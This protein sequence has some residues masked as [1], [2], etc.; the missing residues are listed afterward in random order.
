MRSIIASTDCVTLMSAPKVT[1]TNP[2][3]QEGYA[4]NIISRTTE[5]QETMDNIHII[6]LGHRKQ[7]GKDTVG[8]I[9]QN[10]LENRGVLTNK[11]L[12]A[13][14]LKEHCAERYGLDA[15][16]MHEDE[17]KRWK[18]SWLG[19]R[20]VRDVLLEEGA[21]GRQIWGPVWANSAYKDVLFRAHRPYNVGIITDFR[22]QNEYDCFDE[23]MEVNGYTGKRPILHKVLVHRPDGPIEN[24]GADG[25]LPDRGDYWDYEIINECQGEDW[26]TCLEE[27]C[28]LFIKERIL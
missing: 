5:R 20:T 16:K 4:E 27:Q 21:L 6:L 22:F 15:S 3:S 10:F 23:L 2:Q 11:T 19:G 25:E 8:A 7:H 28:I 9:L 17:Y 24:D 14:V 12:F 13:R 26:V 1:A 18:P